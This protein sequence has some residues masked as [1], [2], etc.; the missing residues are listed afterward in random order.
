MVVTKCNI[1]GRDDKGRC[2]RCGKI[3]VRVSRVLKKADAAL[4]QSWHESKIDKQKFFD[5]ASPATGT[6]LLNIIRAEVEEHKLLN[7]EITHTG[8]GH[9]MSLKE[10]EGKYANNPAR[11]AAIMQN[12][13]KVYCDVSECD[14][15][16]DMECTSIAASTESHTSTT[17]R[18]LEAEQNVKPVK[19]GTGTAKAAKIR[20][21]TVKAAKIRKVTKKNVINEERLSRVQKSRKGLETLLEE[22]KVIED[23]LW[24]RVE[25]VDLIPHCVVKDIASS[26]LQIE[27]HNNILDELLESKKCKDFKTF[28]TIMHNGKDCAS[29]VKEFMCRTKVQI[30][31]AK[32]FCDR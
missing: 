14:L 13:R 2:R 10:M 22:L 30:T 28:K 29:A 15:F 8:T 5:K 17:K 6:E 32:G 21:V 26:R 23:E 11:L 16:E 25:L 1:C 9:F 12:T 18:S 3:A 27:T 20:E 31:E 19:K 7:N 4:V 24:H